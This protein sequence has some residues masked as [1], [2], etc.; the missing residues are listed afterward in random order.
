MMEAAAVSVELVEYL[1]L[2]PEIF[3][4]LLGPGR[5]WY[6]SLSVLLLEEGADTEI[7]WPRGRWPPLGETGPD[8]AGGKDNLIPAAPLW[9]DTTAWPSP[10]WLGPPAPV[11]STAALPSTLSFSSC[12]CWS[13]GL[14][15]EGALG[16]GASP[17]TLSDSM[18]ALV[19]ASGNVWSSG[20]ELDLLSPWPW[21]WV[22]VWKGR[23][24]PWLP[25]V[26]GPTVGWSIGIAPSLTSSRVDFSSSWLEVED[27]WKWGKKKAL[28]FK[29][30]QYRYI[31]MF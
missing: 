21:D 23:S 8:C 11:V 13:W 20:E 19:K 24:G 10:A 15:S 3:S 9:D 4:A 27:D 28:Y 22:C 26:D 12:G 1:G 17:G 5:L 2:S 30:W 14:P 7:V 16:R 31:C 25:G 18:A 29:Q 6:E